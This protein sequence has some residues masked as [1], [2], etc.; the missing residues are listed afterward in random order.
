MSEKTISVTEAARNFADCIN[1]VRYQGMS[2]ILEKNGEPVAR[3]VPAMEKRKVSTGALLAAAL[4]KVRLTD[5]EFAA[6][7]RDLEA[8]RK[9]LIPPV[10]KWQ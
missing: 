10:D 3:I 4:E 6:W 5:E 7:R 2:F 8:A 1:R 9:M